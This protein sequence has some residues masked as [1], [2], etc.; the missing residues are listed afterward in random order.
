M[1]VDRERVRKMLIWG[2]PVKIV[3]ERLD[4]SKRHV[5]RIRSQCDVEHKVD[6]FWGTEWERDW[7]WGILRDLDYSD[8]QIAEIVGRTPQAVHQW[9]TTQVEKE[10][11]EKSADPTNWH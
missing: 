1:A 2:A 8:A 11:K 10:R 3:A 9:R 7:V 5:R 4:C 6:A